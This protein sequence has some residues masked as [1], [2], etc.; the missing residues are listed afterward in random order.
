MS[1]QNST[2]YEPTEKEKNLLEVLINPDYRMKSITD[3]C[4]AAKCT[5][6]IY[7]N[8]FEKPGFV[9]LYKQYTTNLVK[10]SVASVINTFIR[11]AQRGSFQHG[12][13]LLEMAGLYTDKIEI[14]GSVPVQIIDDIPRGG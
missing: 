5:R 3:I 6:N 12:K 1:K 2:N 13:V 14:E 4:R 9:E 7:Y 8:A 10:Q 11:E